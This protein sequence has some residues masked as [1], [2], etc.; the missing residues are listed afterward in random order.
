MF[1]GRIDLLYHAYWNIRYIIVYYSVKAEQDTGGGGG[2]LY[3][4]WSKRYLS[5][6]RFNEVSMLIVFILTRRNN[7]ITIDWS[8]WIY[9]VLVVSS[10]IKI[11]ELE[12]M[13]ERM[14]V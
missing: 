3:W 7:Y 14:Q 13:S 10:S 5:C 12:C 2:K 9:S 6:L 8:I 11:Y 1:Y 4:P